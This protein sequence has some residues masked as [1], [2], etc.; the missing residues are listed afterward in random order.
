MALYLK[1]LVLVIAINVSNFM[2]VSK[3]CAICRVA[4]RAP[5]AEMLRDV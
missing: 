4:K 5:C 3:K 2:L 1:M